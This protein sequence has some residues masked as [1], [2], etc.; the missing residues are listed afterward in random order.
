MRKLKS[1]GAHTIMLVGALSLGGIGMAAAAEQVCTLASTSSIVLRGS[2][3]LPALPARGELTVNCGD[4][5]A[6]TARAECTCDIVSLAPL[7]LVGVGFICLLPTPGCSAG[8]VDCNGG[9]SISV[10][11]VSDHNIGTCCTGDCNADSAVSIDEL[12]SGVNIALGTQAVDTCPAFAP[13]GSEGIDIA[14]LVTAVNTSLNGCNGNQQCGAQCEAYCAAMDKVPTLTQRGCEGFCDG[15]ERKDLPCNCDSASSAACDATAVGSCPGGACSGPDNVGFGSICECQC[16]ERATGVVTAPGGLKCNLGTNLIVERPNANPCV[17][18]PADLLIT[19]GTTCVPLTTD[20]AMSE[21]MHLNNGTVT[22]GPFEETG[23]PI[24]C[25]TLDTGTSG[26]KL[27]GVVSF[28][29]SAIG[30][31]LSQVNVDCE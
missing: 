22:L 26:L 23:S 13:V 1:F 20:L 21:L 4:P 27:R 2:L 5:D 28:F 24:T 7:Q 10:D 9:D 16:I 6:E 11:L 31:L 3:T 15:G 17:G 14:K 19:V 25:E 18:N 8:Q 29:G 12:I 30:D